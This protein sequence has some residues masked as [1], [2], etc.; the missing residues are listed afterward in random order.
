M[1][2]FPL[3]TGHCMK[4]KTHLREASLERLRQ[5]A[6]FWELLPLEPSVAEDRDGLA[7]YL[8]PR[9]QTTTNFRL[10]FDKLDGREREYIYL[11]ALH[12]GELPGEEFRRRARLATP[13]AVS[14]LV[15]HV[16]QHGF[17][18]REKVRDELI[19]LDLVGIPEPF[20]RLIELPPYWQGFL[21]FYLQ[22]L[23]TDELKAIAKNTLDERPPT[24]KKQALVHYLRKKLLDPKQL[25]ALL[26]RRENL[27]LEMFQQ[28]L[29]K[30]GVCAWKDLLDS[31]VH[32]KFDHVRAERLR[33]LVENSG[34]VFVLRAAPN[35]YNNL[36]M[37]PR[38]LT[39][40][41]Q[42]GYHK[43]ERTLDE[44]SHAGA[45]DH[46]NGNGGESTLR[47]GVILDN[48]NNI[49]R[50]L[51]I[52]CAYIQRNQ[53]KML[54][55]GGLGR[56][57][58]KKIA[59]LL[60]YNKTT[61][62]V[63][64]LALFAMTRKLIIP[65]GDQWRVSS[66]LAPWL[67]KGQGCYRD[68]YEFW[69]TTNEWNEEFIEGDVVHTDNYPQNLIS[70]TELR[71]LVLRMLEKTPADSWIDFETFAESLL[72]QIAIEIPGRFDLIPTEKFN[73]HPVLIME[74]IV[75][76]TL[77]W[78]GVIVLGVADLEVSRRL[79]SRPNEAIAPYDPN[80]P[81]S[82]RLIGEGNLLFCFRLSDF[83]RLLMTRPYLEP[84][85]LFAKS[86][87]PELP[88]AE[89]ADSFTVQ[90]NL[91]IVTPPDLSVEQFYRLL[92]FT[93]IK[94]VDVMTTLAI[95]RDSVRAGLDLGQT[96]ESMLGLLKE[97]SRKE[98]PETVRQMIGECESRHGEVDM[99]L[100]G[101]Y[102]IVS[103]R[104]R[105]EELK[106]NP[107]IA[108]EI[109][110]IFD[111]RL[112]LLSRTADFKKIAKELQRIGYM[113]RVDSDSV[114]VT[115]DG[116]FQITLQAQE[117]YD[118][119]AVVQFAIMMEEEAETPVFEDRARPLF[120]RL[121]SA[122]QE[123]F[124]PKFYAESIAKSFYANFDKLKRKL[125]DEETRKY[126]KQVNRLISQVPRAKTGGT[127]FKGENP[128]SDPNEIARMVKYAIEHELQVKIH[129]VK[130][131]GEAID[132]V[133]EPEQIQDHKIYGFCPA[134]DEHH[135]FAIE[136]IQHAAI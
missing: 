56:N 81:L 73:R 117:L 79:G 90:P 111:E 102:L 44:L 107:K 61:K 23:G 32:K 85:K 99:G 39:Y 70:I 116:L 38:D 119:L 15:E 40:I 110:D 66:S 52:V 131:S 41:I 33:D 3:S 60:S 109:K 49:L 2:R 91:E 94:K 103:D 25:Q 112:I 98:L 8:Y 43:D 36:L 46:G 78:L 77:H 67:A 115:N 42:N 82:A 29:Q 16:G 72:P 132:E 37:V 83:G 87:D 95:S 17:L 128:T 6:E 71:K 10:A 75:A 31:G 136:R 4:L 19:N 76:E 125:I 122:S 84:E 68:L 62:Y 89:Q 86:P 126:R 64:F 30:N 114:Y 55:N 100:A 7:E 48:S 34:L 97:C 106:A 12:G 26:G 11:L 24:R 123:K 108:P 135:V 54:N 57:D 101:G 20:V 80:H 113:P 127:S 45:G 88:Y 53:I 5:I 121:S 133:I 21:G 50:D 118:L 124:N 69:L 51:T 74:S 65:V 96:A 134:R 130:S 28:I 129:Y 47:P 59:P 93:D 1:V 18:W 22:C 35:K 14:E 9:M 63:S 92:Q 13:E 104:M 105:V 58:L 120:Q 27:Q